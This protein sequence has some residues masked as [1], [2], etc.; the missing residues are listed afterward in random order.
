MGSQ[1]TKYKTSLWSSAWKRP[2]LSFNPLLLLGLLLKDTENSFT[3]S[4]RPFWSL[5]FRFP[6]LRVHLDIKLQG[7]SQQHAIQSLMVLYT[8][9]RLRR[10]WKI[11]KE[12]WLYIFL[13]R[14]I[15]ATI[16]EHLLVPESP[17]GS[18]KSL[19]PA[20]HFTFS[21]LWAAQ[22]QQTL[23]AG[24]SWMSAPMGAMTLA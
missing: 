18:S 22:G 20:L 15:K 8:E 23:W 7:S 24:I 3:S 12:I 1:Y 10:I 13:P 9:S 5:D 4:L 17:R 14:N 16:M 2:W 19:L 11:L 21:W 6:C